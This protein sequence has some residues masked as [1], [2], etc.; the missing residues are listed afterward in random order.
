[1]G[2]ELDY[3]RTA[4]GLVGA[5]ATSSTDLY[6]G[7]NLTMLFTHAWNLIGE[8][9][10]YNKARGSIVAGVGGTYASGFL[11]GLIRG[12]YEWRLAR[13]WAVSAALGYRPS[14]TKFVGTTESGTI[15]GLD[16]TF[17]VSALF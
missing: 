15:S 13:H 14:A 7:L 10:N 9:E 12:G 5:A 11:G 8:E 1:M 16:Y 2:F 4:S 17:G 6:S 3:F